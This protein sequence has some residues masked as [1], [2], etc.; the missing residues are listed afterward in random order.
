MEKAF[1]GR[2]TTNNNPEEQTR[3]GRRALGIRDGE[4]GKRGKK[5]RDRIGLGN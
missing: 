3:A 1:G 2:E 5:A 4:E